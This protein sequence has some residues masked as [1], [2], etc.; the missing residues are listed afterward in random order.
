MPQLQ[1]VKIYPPIGIARL[2]NSPEWFVGQ[3]LPFPAAPPV[4]SD[5][6]YKDSQCRIRRQAQRF[7][8][9]G[10]FDDGSA[11]ELT[12]ADGTIQWTVH[13]ANAKAVFRGEAGGLI[14]PGP[15]TL[16][17][18]NDSASFANGT[19]T[20]SGQTVEVPL[21]D[22]ITDQDGRLIVMGGFGFSSSPV[23]NG[24]SDFLDNAGWH[25][26]ISDGPV[27]ATITVGGKKFIAVGAWIICP[28]PRFAPSTYSV[29]TLYDTIRQGA[30]DQGLLPQPGQPSFVS[31]IWPILSRGIGMLRVAA[32]VF[33]P[34]DHDSLSSVI[35]PGPGQDNTRHAILNKLANPANP[36]NVGQANLPADMPLLFSGGTLPILNETDVPPALRPFQYTQM[37]AWSQ[38]NFTN[39]WPP[40]APTV[41]TPDGLTR[42]ALEGCVGAP[43][44][45]GIEATITVRDGSIKYIEPFRF[46]QT[47]L[48]PGDVT[49]AM[50]RPWQADFTDCSGGNSPDGA[51]WWPGARPDSVYPQGST[52]PA[53]WTRGL[54]TSMQDMVD[55]W[56]RLGFIVDP[57]NGE[58]VETERTAVCKDCF[59]IT[60][61][62][63]IG[64]EEAA[65]LVEANQAIIDAFYVVVEGFAPLDLGINTP[66]P[67][68]LQLQSSAP[69]ISFNPIPTEM[70]QQVNDLTLEDNGALNQAQRITFGYNITFTGT[71]DFTTDVVPIQLNASIQGVFSNA[72]INL[73]KV[74]SPYMDHGP[75]SWLSNDTRVFKVQPG[76][77]VVGAP[78][79]AND[80]IAFIQDVLK[81]LR[82]D[83]SPDIAYGA[84]E[85]LPAGE[86]ASELE[87]LPTLNNQPVYNFALCRI[88]YRAT[89][90]TASNV[91]V[92]FR[93]FQTASTGTDYNSNTTYR[94]GGH[95]GVKI[96]LL[97]IQGGELVTIPFFAE[98]RK[99]AS[100][101][102]NQQSDDTNVQSISPAPGGKEAYMYYGCWLDI[103]Q[104]NDLRFPIQP[105]PPDGGPFN[106]T[107]LSIADL[108][109]GTHQCLVTEINFDLDPITPQGTST[110][111]SDK[112][113]QR[114]L[115]IDNSEN[116]GSA[117]THRVQHTFA[118]RPTTS[119]PLP[120]QGPDEMMISWGNTPPGT[121]ATIYLP[122]VRVSEVLDLAARNFNLQTLERVDDHTLRCKTAGVT[123]VPIPAGGALELAGLITLDLPPT[124]R[125][126]QVFRVVVRQ[127]TD[128]PAPQPAPPPPNPIPKID[129]AATPQGATA[130]AVERRSTPSRHIL[131]AF[132]FSI[133]V[134]TAAEMLPLDERDLTVIE[135]VVG[136]IPAE[137]RWFPVFQRYISQLGARVKALG[138]EPGPGEER[139]DYEGKISGL[140]F[141]RFGDF[142]GF[143]L[144]TEDGKRRFYSREKHV[145]ELVRTAW[146][147]RI[148]VLVIV[149]R[150]ERE[151]PL[152]IVLLRPP[153]QL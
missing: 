18:P 66:N 119:N 131:G 141:D 58:P 92:F 152:N 108:I 22:A 133:L 50:A 65:A 147:Q 40:V 69:N 153:V 13:L 126:G 100:V 4:P 37:Q 93:I 117:E 12:A 38:G 102:L 116:P 51:A 11:R 80:P 52:M 129:L 112:L 113:S 143:W 89:I 68:P 1:T 99:A 118:I 101:N 28:P 31:D 110:A 46:D 109:R 9:W 78:P 148:A 115:A 61:R 57:G 138:G 71:N 30:I 142:E 144:D 98:A 103:N 106:G 63:E 145:E 84:F 2:G 85:S 83:L 14:D 90:T 59:I 107:L 96:P 128:T 42:A 35:P 146:T 43:F 41:V 7:R 34:G 82:S 56:Y 32:A 121:A 150:H 33:S 124:V 64:M 73:T 149:E 136:K 91:R 97:G 75:I 27:N 123:Y 29:I 16:N 60:D 140:L 67:S 19:Y 139:I 39:D 26:D 44:F 47:N 79:L 105:S 17:G 76:G 111:S 122:G 5:G 137:N 135:R 87:W 6:K 95:P 62:N 120:K 15:R 3:E 94:V 48:K 8:L 45:P 81:H 86:N 88:R 21:G 36:T 49:R 104:P 130:A 132:Q 54:V 10:Y 55:N 70:K 151:K 72:V 25:D 134:K 114:N 23:G 20:Y 53:D 77:T 127:V 24:L 125:R 74:D